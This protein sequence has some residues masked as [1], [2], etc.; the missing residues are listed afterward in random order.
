MI[1]DAQRESEDLLNKVQGLLNAKQSQSEEVD[2]AAVDGGDTFGTS[3]KSS[4]KK[5]P[6]VTNFDDL[7]S[8]EAKIEAELLGYQS[9][10]DR[11]DEVRQQLRESGSRCRFFPD[12]YDST[13]KLGG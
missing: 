12:Q 9:N 1:D 6:T 5:K 7:V 13:L 10:A 8:E 2:V 4:P 11:P 3:P